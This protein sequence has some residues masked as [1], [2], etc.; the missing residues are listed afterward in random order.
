MTT[1]NLIRCSKCSSVLTPAVSKLECE[2]KPNKIH[3]LSSLPRKV[4][5]IK[6]SHVFMP[7]RSYAAHGWTNYLLSYS[8]VYQFAN[9]L[10]GFNPKRMKNSYVSIPH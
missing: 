5:Q 9:M 3:F 8:N 7:H 6:N 10:L 4:D 2:V 1:E